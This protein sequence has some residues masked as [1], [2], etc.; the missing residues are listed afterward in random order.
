MKREELTHYLDQCL[1]SDRF[2]DY[3]PNGLQVEGCAE[4]KQVICGVTANQA[5]VDEAVRRGAD[6]L[7]VHHGWF[8]RGE[9]GAITGFRKARL[10][11]LLSADI[12]LIAYHLPLDAHPVVGNNAQLA[13]HLGWVV[14]GRFG[15]QNL[16][17]FGS[18]QE[19]TTWDQLIPALARVLGRAP[20][21]VGPE[22][23]ERMIGRIA[24]CSGAGQSLFEQ[25]IDLGVDVFVSGEVS[26][27]SVHLARESGTA[28]IAAGHHATER[29]GVKALAALLGERFSL[30]CDYVEV[31]SPV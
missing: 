17:C 24:W 21:V 19:P 13:Q 25:A 15:D 16:G 23:R 28:Y 11:T 20:L 10:K 31:D 2:K 7:L 29:F 3:C 8:W 26:E 5:L 6:T 27:S 30:A 12:N 4:V 1:E 22:S 18:P 9:T 14:D